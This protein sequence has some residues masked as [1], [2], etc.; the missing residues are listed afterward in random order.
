MI[1]HKA[2]RWL[3]LA[4]ISLVGFSASA[5]A[6]GTNHLTLLRPGEHGPQVASLQ[7][8]LGALGYT[9]GPSDGVYGP[10]TASALLSFEH[11]DALPSQSSLSLATASSLSLALDRQHFVSGLLGQVTLEVGSSGPAVATLQWSLQHLGLYPTP[12]TDVF[13]QHTTQAVQAFEVQHHLASSRQVSPTL[14]AEVLLA[15][16]LQFALPVA[17][18]A[19]A[20]STVAPSSVAASSSAAT[21]ALGAAPAPS[22]PGAPWVLGYYTEWQGSGSRTAYRTAG[23]DFN[24]LAPLWYGVRGSGAVFSRGYGD[25]ASLAAAWNKNHQQVLALVTNVGDQM[26]QSPGSMMLAVSNLVRIVQNDGLAGVNIDFENLGPTDRAP[27]TSFMRALTK[28]LHAIGKL[29]TIAVGAKAKNDPATNPN[30]AAY[31]YQA[32]GQIADAVVIMTYDEHDNGS[33]PGPVAGITWVK[34]DLTYALSRMPATKVLLGIADYGYD[35]SPMGTQSVSALQAES[36]AALHGVS[37][38]WDS[39]AEEYHFQYQDARGRTHSVWF[40][41]GRSVV[42]KLALAKALGL[43]GVALWMMGGGGPNLWQDLAH[44]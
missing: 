5:L 38:Q 23:S 41:N 31:D 9:V 33:S 19:S 15:S 4:C 42:Y 40:E 10:L 14:G 13:G 7:G 36:M 27:L 25:Q 20:S 12:P 16:A 2:H 30:G 6:A 39:V 11:Q 3:S 28:Q 34:R 8:R 43:K 37:P 32:L 26:L 1:L 29:A 21:P 24:V 18:A 17:S 44:Y 22:L 35:W